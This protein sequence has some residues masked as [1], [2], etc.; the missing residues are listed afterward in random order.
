MLNDKNMKW[1]FCC[2]CGNEF[3]KIEGVVSRIPGEL[4]G[5]YQC[6][7]CSDNKERKEMISK[8][9]PAFISFDHDIG[10][11]IPTRIRIEIPFKNRSYFKTNTKYKVM[12]WEDES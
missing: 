3:V 5:T 11:N 6:V 8:K 10:D 12:V 9:S 1:N 4:K 2:I 7:T